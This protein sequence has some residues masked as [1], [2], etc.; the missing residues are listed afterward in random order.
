MGGQI[1]HELNMY[2]RMEQFPT[3]HPG[4][5]AIRTLLDTFYIDGPADKH[6][7]LVHRPLWESV[8]TFLRR[9]PAERLPSAVV[10]YVLQRV[11]LALDYL[12][13][14]CQITHTGILHFCFFFCTLLFHPFH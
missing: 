13:T 10:V 4:R 5:D 12:H 11:F 1:D 6:C 8:L 7:C 2:R 9:N 14:E 3:S